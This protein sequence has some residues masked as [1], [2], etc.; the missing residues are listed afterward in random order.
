MEVI[1]GSKKNKGPKKD[2]QNY[3]RERKIWFIIII[4]IRMEQNCI[5]EMHI[6]NDFELSLRLNCCVQ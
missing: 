2:S 6:S 4:A 1:Y 5:F 3:A